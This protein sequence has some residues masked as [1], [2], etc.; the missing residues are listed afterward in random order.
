MEAGPERLTPRQVE[1]LERGSPRAADAKHRPARCACST[2]AP[3]DNTCRC[4]ARSGPAPISFGLVSVPVR[5]FTATESKELKFHF[6]DRRDMSPIGYDK[7]N[8]DTGK[9]VDADD[10]I[11][12]FEFEKGRFV[13]LADED[14]DRL[15]IELTHAIDICDFVSIDEIDPLYFR[16]A[17]YLLPAGRRREALPAARQ[18]ARGDRPGR[19]RE[20]RHPQQAAPLMRAAGRQDARARDDVLRRRGAAARGRAGAAGAPGRGRD[21]EV[22]D[23]EPRRPRGIPKRYHD[24]YRNQLLDL[25]EKKAEGEPLPEPQQETGGEVIDLMDALRQSVAATKKKRAPREARSR[26]VRRRRR[27]PRGSAKLPE[28]PTTV[29]PTTGASADPQATPEPF[30]SGERGDAADLRRPAPRREPPPLRLPAR[31]QRR[32]RLVG[33]AERRAARARRQGARRPR[34]GP[35]ARVRRRSR[36]R[37]RRASTAAARSRSGTTARTSCSRRSRTAS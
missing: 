29:S 13:E 2:I 22:A 11:R 34:R 20:D 15:D 27:R 9:H 32:A 37:S 3:V 8:K 24:Q 35:P 36:A 23:R 19:D 30:G 33:G 28:C 16:K 18:G 17:Y 5:L 10:V 21:G 26:P 31:A 6:L 1:K 12:G 7:V 4:H 14:I 25:L